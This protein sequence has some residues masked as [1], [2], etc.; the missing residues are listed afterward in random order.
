MFR[1]HLCISVC[2]CVPVCVHMCTHMCV[3]GVAWRYGKTIEKFQNKKKN[4]TQRQKAKVFG[5]AGAGRTRGCVWMLKDAV[6]TPAL[7]AARQLLQFQ[8]RRPLR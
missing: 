1:L 6:A 2:M 3:R 8:T 4:L 5:E 7:V